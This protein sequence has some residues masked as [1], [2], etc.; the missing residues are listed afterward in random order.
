MYNRLIVFCILILMAIPLSCGKAYR[1]KRINIDQTNA[2]PYHHGGLAGTGSLPQGSFDGRLDILWERGTNEKPTGPLLISH[3]HLVYPGTRRRIKFFDMKDGD[4]L[5][6]IKV[7]GVPQAGMTV[8]DTLGY[9]A[10]SPRKGRVGCVNLLNGKTVWKGRIKDAAA[11]SILIDN[12]LLVVSSAEGTTFGLDKGSGEQLWRFQ[13]EGRYAAPP[14]YDDGKIYQADDL[15]FVYSISPKDGSELGRIKLDGP[16]VSA[17][18]VADNVYAVDLDGTV[19]AVKT[20]LSEI[21]WRNEVGGDCWT[22]TT[23]A[24]GKVIVGTSNGEVVALDAYTGQKQWS[25]VTVD[26]IRAPV[27]VAGSFV[28]CGTMSGML[29]SLSLSEGKPIDQRELDGAIKTSPITDGDRVV[30]ITDKGSITCFG[31]G[32]GYANQN[33]N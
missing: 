25:F 11:G 19:F 16:I 33:D 32:T 15:G 27:I 29:Y 5:G 20:D 23:L 17:V 28:I 7:R 24:D 22:G 4:Y 6:K 26:V 21:L 18:T 8:G 13:A 10:T 14:V 2:W 31:N 30:V 12:R 9:F 3:G 1:L